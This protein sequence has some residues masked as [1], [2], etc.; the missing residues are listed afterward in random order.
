MGQRCAVGPEEQVAERDRVAVDPA[1]PEPLT[2]HEE[3]SLI[4]APSLDR[5][6]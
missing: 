5:A 2:E 6:F 3:H 1:P 4:R